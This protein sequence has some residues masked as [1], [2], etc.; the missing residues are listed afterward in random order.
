MKHVLL[1]FVILI[2]L[3]SMSNSA[4]AE[5]S[6]PDPRK[7]FTKEEI[8]R[9]KSYHR[10]GY[11]MGIIRIA[12]AISFLLLIIY[13]GAAKS[14]NEFLTAKISSYHDRHSAPGLLI[15]L[16]A[17]PFRLCWAV[18]WLQDSTGCS[19]HRLAGG[20]SLLQALSQSTLP[21]LF[22]SSPLS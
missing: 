21:W 12:I 15:F 13:T 20:G 1:G 11:T 7:Y 14:F 17:A 2:L 3:L 18:F 5:S 19:G 6:S 4:A 16:K 22:C 10:T 8:E 9:G